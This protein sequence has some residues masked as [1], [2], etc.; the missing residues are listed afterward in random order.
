MIRGTGVGVTQW[1]G[2]SRTMRRKRKDVRR[3]K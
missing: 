1:L 3:A 2:L